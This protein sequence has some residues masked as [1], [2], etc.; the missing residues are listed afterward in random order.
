MTVRANIVPN[1]AMLAENERAVA[2]GNNPPSPF[3]EIKTEI[4]SLYA[5]AKQWLDGDPITTQGQADDLDKLKHMIRDAEK[6]A[7]ELRKT[8]VK[9]FDDGKAEVQARFAPLIA[10]T[11]SVK[12][13]TVLAREVLNKALTPWLNKLD[14]EKRA[15]EAKANAE[16]EAKRKEAVEAMRLSAVDDLAAREDAEAKLTAAKEAEKAAKRAVN[17]KALAKGGGGRASHL[18]PH[19]TPEI[20]DYTEFARWCWKNQR[21]DMVAFLDG[22][23]K[24]LVR[25]NPER[26][27]PGMA[28]HVER[29]AV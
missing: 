2:G 10:D 19:Y 8:E 11:K 13:M 7:E 18:R 20:T 1:A 16:A 4:E 26:A 24:Q 12:G 27:V 25:E 29:K 23:A 9:P 15:A 3:D 28:I 6:K 5:E 21:S 17:D 14:E 22:M